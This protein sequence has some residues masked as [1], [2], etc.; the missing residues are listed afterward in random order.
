M[1]AALSVALVAAPADAQGSLPGY[2]AVSLGTNDDPNMT[3]AFRS[4][5]RETMEVAGER[6]VVWVNILALPPWRARTTT[7]TTAY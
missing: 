1:L 3:D 6:C 4:A 2:I 7:A 5:I